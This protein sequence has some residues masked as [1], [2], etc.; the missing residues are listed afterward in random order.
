M[1]FDH[2]AIITSALHPSIGIFNLEE[3]FLISSKKP[4]KAKN[5]VEKKKKE[6]S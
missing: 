4:K 3:R 5:T 6:K 1:N 2:I